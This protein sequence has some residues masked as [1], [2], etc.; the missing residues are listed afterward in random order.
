MRPQNISAKDAQ[1]DLFRSRLDQILNRKHPLFQ[2]ANQIDWQ[3]FD[4]EFGQLF[5]ENVGRPGLPTRLIVGLHYL[6]HA[7]NESDESVVGRFLENPYWQH[8]CGYE[9]FQHELPIDP[10]SLVRWRKR[11]G[12]D[13]V[14]KLLVETLETAKRGNLLTKRHVEHV[15][16]DTTVQEKAVAFPTDAR[17][18]Q[19]IRHALV[20]AAKERGIDLRQN[21][22]RL[23]KEALLMQGRYAHARQLKRARKQ[24]R[25]LRIFL[26][27]VTRD[28]KRKCQVP[29][30]NLSKLLALAE[31]IFSQT[32][33]DSNK[34]YSVHAPEVECIAKGKAHK[35]YEF[36]CKVAM[37]TSSIK[38][39]VLAIDALHGNPF[40]G[41]TL[42]QSLEQ[43]K[44]ITG[45]QPLNAYCDRG[46]RGAG[47]DITDTMVHLAGK[48]KKSMKPGIWRWYARRA[49]IEPIFGHLKS[50]NR[51]ERNHLKGKDGDR[52]NAILAGCGF[53]LR[54]LLGAFFLFI[55]YRLYRLILGQTDDLRCQRA[56]DL[57]PASAN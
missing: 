4:S 42:K 29:D 56:V 49:A 26:G 2:L 12:P 21:Y 16:V 5:V 51:L 9:Y 36:G 10:S 43:V 32:R 19:K 23:G 53:N 8:F 20:R 38:N 7:F 24:T 33:N 41:H 46:Y 3:F 30:E 55:F 35:K 34:V 39:W 52:M 31:K 47:K 6:K 50:D 11:L 27:R 15:N 45:W 57:N 1:G 37:V 17:L 14:E 13:R 25:K 54:K 18:Y 40:D 28:I 48:K 44:R 22:E